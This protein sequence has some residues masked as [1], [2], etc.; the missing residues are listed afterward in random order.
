[1]TYFDESSQKCLLDNTRAVAKL[2]QLLI[3]KCFIIFFACLCFSGC[4]HLSDD[5]ST[6]ESKTMRAVYKKQNPSNY[7][8]LWER[9]RKNFDMSSRRHHHLQ[10]RERVQHF[11]R[12]YSTH[13]KHLNHLTKA[14]PY[15]HFIVE[16]LEKRDMP[17][18]L[19]LLPMIESAFDSRATSRKGAAGLWQFIPGTGRQFGLKQDKWYD[20]RRDVIAST[21]AALDY[22]QFLHKEF[23]GNWM[24]A[25]AAY[26][27]GPGTIH[28]AIKKNQQSGKPTNF[29]SLKLPR[30]TQQYVPKFLALAE[31]VAN[32]NKHEICLPHIEN[33]PYFVSVD[34]GKQACLHKVA[35]LADMNVAEL[36]RLNAGYR[37]TSTHPTGP[38]RLI[39]PVI[40]AEKFE[41]NLSKG[42]INLMDSKYAKTAN[43]PIRKAVKPKAP[44]AKIAKAKA[45]AKPKVA[46]PKVLKA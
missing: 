17:G 30:E 15:L 29:W 26:N 5:L 4:D 42:K 40:N 11:V 3:S 16:E 24:L 39:M 32:P 31:V 33:K 18:E 41:D 28:R 8:A 45:K 6:S 14:S 25:L 46:K 19:A 12:L 43:T 36:K 22:L 1:M 34:P 2:T 38:K 13:E 35:E 7:C 21:R 23:N 9:V 37:K 44:K 27:A 20:G 10:D